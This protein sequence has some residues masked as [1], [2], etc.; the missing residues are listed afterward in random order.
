MKSIHV[1]NPHGRSSTEA[2]AGG[3]FVLSS[4]VMLERITR[5]LVNWRVPVKQRAREFETEISG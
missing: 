1:T 2:F 4:R 3:F 5:R